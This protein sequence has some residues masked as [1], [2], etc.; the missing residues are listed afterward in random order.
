MSHKVNPDQVMLT[1]NECKNHT[2]I[3][4]NEKNGFKWYKEISNINHS[5]DQL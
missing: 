2:F 1:E 4:L 3:F 5:R